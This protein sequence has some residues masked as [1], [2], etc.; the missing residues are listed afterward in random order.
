MRPA[1]CVGRVGGLAAALGVGFAIWLGSPTASADDTSTS[2]AETASPDG[3]RQAAWTP[4]KG[5]VSSRHTED[6]APAHAY[7]NSGRSTRRSSDASTGAQDRSVK[8]EV[9]NTDEE[10]LPTKRIRS[11]R[12]V[13]S[14][15]IQPSPVPE[16]PSAP[17]DSPLGTALL[18]LGSRTRDDRLD[19]ASAD[20]LSLSPAA[21]ASQAPSQE[22]D[23]QANAVGGVTALGGVTVTGQ[24]PGS[25][26]LSADGTRAVMV[27]GWPRGR[28]TLASY[29][30]GV[31]GSTTRV[32]VIDT[33]TGRQVGTTLRITGDHPAAVQ[34]TADGSRVV[35][36]SS[37]SKT[38]VAVLDTRT[39]AQVGTTFTLTGGGSAQ[40]AGT[41]S[42]ALVTAT[43]YSPFTRSYT[44][45]AAVLNTTTGTRVGSTFTLTGRGSAVVS[46]DG[47]RAVLFGGSTT[48]VINTVTGAQVGPSLADSWSLQAWSADGT[49][50]LLTNTDYTATGVTTRVAM[51]DTATGAQIGTTLGVVGSG[52]VK[53]SAATNRAVVTTTETN[54]SNTATRVAVF[55]T[56]TGTQRG[57]TLAV[58]GESSTA[59]S[60]D[61]TRVLITADLYDPA[62]ALHTTQVTVFNT[63]TGTLAGSLTLAGN[64]YGR[65]PV[66]SPD[67]TRALITTDV[68]DQASTLHTSRVTMFDTANGA[69]IGAALTLTGPDVAEARWRADGT[70][71][72][73]TMT[74][75]QYDTVTSPMLVAVVDSTGTQV[76]TTLS[77]SGMPGYL[78]QPVWNTGGTRALITTNTY[79][80]ITGVNTTR[81]TTINTTTGGQVG[82]TV[83]L[84]SSAYSSRTVLI[85]GNSRAVVMAGEHLAVIDIATG[86]QV[87]ATLTVDGVPSV[88][89][90]NTG[91]TRALVS[92]GSEF[93]VIDTATG[94][95]VGTTITVAHS[96][97]RSIVTLLTPDGTHALITT[98]RRFIGEPFD[99]STPVA[100][101]DLTTGAQTGSTLTVVGETYDSPVF[102][103]DGT[104]AI[105]STG[106]DDVATGLS[107]ARVTTVDTRTG[108]Q[109]GDTITVAGV[110]SS[111][112]GNPIRVLMSPNGSRALLA[113]ID[114]PGYN[115]GQVRTIDTATGEQVGGVAAVDGAISGLKWS[116]DGT[117]VVVTSYITSATGADRSVRVTV[118]TAS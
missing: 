60:P 66:F 6:D 64:P 28:V 4:R 68:Y 52:S 87:G 58:T 12:L 1:Q 72:L 35:V 13:Q 53:Y 44:T 59:S 15:A 34:L 80:Q 41:G 76:G 56:A 103:P 3:N 81:A 79:D 48:A 18:A 32:A 75:T 47:T 24:R 49:R 97:P 10:P 107:T 26:L 37:A 83:T 109:V 39:G 118:L 116:A 63:V 29:P 55:D 25:V 33:G 93:A 111:G 106:F 16:S 100:V 90:L 99:P 91:G 30:D 102:T 85:P 46:P 113:T 19:G 84:T 57:T 77:L 36:A 71:A 42:R 104:H 11:L 20:R 51:L 110:L 31:F 5:I 112:V 9:P 40:L 54:G 8:V 43:A 69:Q 22:L 38:R 2:S 96:G 45:R 73:I 14:R 67:A 74:P 105:I 7:G 23:S 86:T 61:G 17:V 117:R 92:W 21:T 95:Q 108:L 65:D 115:S 82:T 27:T 88:S 70:R 101:V 78:D 62:T 89:L 50:A 114:Q 98:Q 94:S